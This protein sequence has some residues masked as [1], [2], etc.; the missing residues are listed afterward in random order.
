MRTTVV[1]VRRLTADDFAPY[2]TLVAGGLGKSDFTRPKL[3]NW[4]LC[5]AS[6]APL[7]LKVMRYHAQRMVLLQSER[8]LCITETRCPIG[9]VQG[10]LVVAG[11]TDGDAPPCRDTIRAFLIDGPG[12][13]LKPDVWHGL[14]CFP[15]RA[16]SADFLFLSDAAT[17]DEIETVASGVRTNVVDLAPAVFEIIDPDGLLE[18][19][20]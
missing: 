2:G 20:P 12:V 17:E 7:R 19:A 18:A 4:R 3:E 11:K 9:G 15:V 6:D 14:D 16:P 1:P 13:M 8:H 5:F 10:V